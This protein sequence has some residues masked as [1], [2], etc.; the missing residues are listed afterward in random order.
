MTAAAARALA[1]VMRLQSSAGWPRADI[2]ARP[3]FLWVRTAD[4]RVDPGYQ[5]T[6]GARSAALIRDMVAAWDWR[7]VQALTV[8]ALPDALWELIDGQHRATAAI[9]HGGI[10][11][12]PAMV[13]QA[14]TAQDRASAFVRL[15]GRRLAVTPGQ[16]AR[17]ALA[18]GDPDM[19]QAMA[20]AA[21]AGV[22]VCFDPP[23][24]PWRPGET[25]AVRE[26]ARHAADNAE[27]LRRA[28]M[29]CRKA[30]LAPIRAE[31][32]RAAVRATSCDAAEASVCAALSDWDR[33]VDDAAVSAMD[34]GL[35]RRDALTAEFGRRCFGSPPPPATRIAATPHGR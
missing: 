29:A 10:P 25:I 19:T 26:L 24:R 30:G 31:H 22:S 35:T 32:L 15:N 16:K 5:R 12:L 27:A 1:P 2:A 20:I 28:L 33:I 17:A 18:G 6:L 34:G 4:L 8:A 11:L 14:D 9:T 3:E 23:G 21:E 7:L 13:V